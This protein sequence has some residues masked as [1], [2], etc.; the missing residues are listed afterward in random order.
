V[1]AAEP[2]QPRPRRSLVPTIIASLAGVALLIW[3]V[4]R[5]GLEEI[6]DGFTAVGASGFLLVLALSLARFALRAAA[7]RAL[8]P[9][10]VRF[11]SAVGAAMAGD[12]VGNLTP[13]SILVGE[14]AKA[15]YLSREVS[16]SRAF[17]TL[18]AENFFYSVSVAIYVVLGTAAMLLAFPAPAV[19]RQAGVIALVMM[20]G[21]LV[22][23]VWMAW[24]RP[25]LL[26]G[27]AARMPSA[28][29]R[30]TVGRIRAFEVETYG[31]AGREGRRLAA[32]VLAEATFHVLSFVEVWF[33]LWLL[34]GQ[35]LPLEA[36][37][38]DTFSR[39]VNVVFK[40]VPLRL[41]VDDSVSSVVAEA[42]ALTSAVGLTVALVRRGRMLVWAAIGLALMSRRGL[43]S[44]ADPR[45]PS[46]S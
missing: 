12:A 31:S 16:A 39:I 41:G 38:L 45:S 14:P 35:S 21:V 40:I 7:W 34:A 2:A 37:V 22:A 13:L 26:S 25:S 5:V 20:A 3:Q 23:A 1:T 36:F 19:L 4:Q 8:I 9:E 24:Q 42:I 17:S 43:T 27:V 32:V 10:R 11:T 28:R 30:A 6:G 18:A 15:M 46:T 29:L 33:V 44:P